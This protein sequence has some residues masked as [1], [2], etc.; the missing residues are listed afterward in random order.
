MEKFFKELIL[1]LTL[2]VIAITA[3]IVFFNSKDIEPLLTGNIGFDVKIEKVKSLEIQQLDVLAIGSSICLNNLHSGTIMKH[4]GQDYSYYNFAAAGLTVDYMLMALK[5]FL[6]KYK[7]KV[8]LIVSSPTDFE[9][10]KM[11]LCSEKDLNLYMLGFAKPYFYLKNLDFF[12]LYRRHRNKQKDINNCEKDHLGS[13]C[14]DQGGGISCV[15][16]EENQLKH[17]WDDEIFTPVVDDQYQ[18]LD[19]LCKLVKSYRAKLLFVQPPM[20]YQNC[21]SQFCKD[22]LRNHFDRSSKIIISAGHQFLNL[23]ED[24][25]YPDS[26]FF[27]EL[28]LNFEGPARF[29]EQMVEEIDV[30]KLVANTN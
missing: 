9:E 19:E 7:P 27:D 10:T 3:L 18:A 17:R 5:V 16:P 15:I 24:N 22:G 20:R 26:L 11:E 23:F 12:N 25:P 21:Q 13:L 4:L 30:K 28:H 14:F 8:I 1:F 2:A 29:T 6:P